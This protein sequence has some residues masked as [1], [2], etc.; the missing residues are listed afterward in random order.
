[1]QMDAGLDTGPV[2]LE[3]SVDIG[4]EA[5]AGSLTAELA[6]LGG[7]LIVAALREMAAGRLRARPQPLLGVTYAHKVEKSEAWIDWSQPAERLGARVRAFDPFPGAY[8][9]L[10]GVMIKIW[11]A[12]ACATEAGGSAGVQPGSVLRADAG[13]IDVACGQGVLRLTQLQRPGGRRLEVRDFL[14]G[15]AVAAGARWLSTAREGSPD[16]DRPAPAP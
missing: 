15:T 16:P 6:Q 3:E 8:S 1:M 11:R 9:S 10:D 7:R 13:G 5:T 4:P 2:L 14:A 12:R